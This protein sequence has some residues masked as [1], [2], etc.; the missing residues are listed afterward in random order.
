MVDGTQ[1]CTRTKGLESKPSREKS[2]RKGDKSSL[3][4]PLPGSATSIGTGRPV[5]RSVP[6]TSR[7]HLTG[8]KRSA[9]ADEVADLRRS[10]TMPLHRKDSGLSLVPAKGA[11]I[12]LKE[13]VRIELHADPLRP[14]TMFSTYQIAHLVTEKCARLFA[15]HFAEMRWKGGAERPQNSQ[16]SLT[17]C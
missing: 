6:R 9:S 15:A 3:S 14:C 4:D 11:L 2:V 5:G 10:S 13:R 1:V 8:R 7:F 16:N 12:A 17:R